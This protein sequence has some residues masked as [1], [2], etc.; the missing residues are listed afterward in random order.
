[1]I[2]LGKWRSARLW[3]REKKKC[4][5][6]D[7]CF[8][9]V[10]KFCFSNSCGRRL[11]RATVVQP[12]KASHRYRCRFGTCSTSRRFL[13][14]FPQ[15]GFVVGRPWFLI[16]V[17]DFF[18]LFHFMQSLW[19]SLPKSHGFFF[20][21]SFVSLAFYLIKCGLGNAPR[22]ISLNFY[23]T[24]SGLTVAQHLHH[25]I[26]S[27]TG[28]TNGEHTLARG[29]EAQHQ[30][31]C[32]SRGPPFGCQCHQINHIYLHPTRHRTIWTN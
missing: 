9:F 15:F 16:F 19:M 18:H 1:M 31:E 6:R 27:G 25:M 2:A 30:F 17:F 20:V 24:R 28:S 13:F 22:E 11:F 29:S 12:R 3:L 4:D 5:Q 21:H 26:Y 8:F 23:C 14:R 7:S 32:S 10:N